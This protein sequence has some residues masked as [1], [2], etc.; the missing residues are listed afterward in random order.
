MFCVHCGTENPDDSRFCS[1]CGQTIQS[2]QL[3]QSRG[4]LPSDTR[5]NPPSGMT[6]A[7][8]ILGL[9]AGIMLFLGGCSAA[10]TGTVAQ[11]IEETFGV[12]ESSEG[13]T[14]TTD[15]VANGGVF[16]I[17]ISIVLFLG[18]GLAKAALKTSL[19]ILILV[20]PMLFGLV[21]VDTTS[22]FASFYY[23]AIPL[24]GT[25]IV[26]MSIAYIRSKRIRGIPS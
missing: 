6:T 7:T 16:A 19:V 23:L 1:S 9:I 8:L 21:A 17:I 4:M 20:M 11:G 2:G 12:E 5:G 18:A 15:D 25:G 26:L 10:F 13:T 3:P 24:V 14:S 22:L